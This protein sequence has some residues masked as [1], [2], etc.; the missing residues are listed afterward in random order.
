MKKKT[1]HIQSISIIGAYNTIIKWSNAFEILSAKRLQPK[2][3][4]PALAD[5]TDGCTLPKH[6]P[7]L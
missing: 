3:A 7:L 5:V 2:T 4:D 1:G 6:L